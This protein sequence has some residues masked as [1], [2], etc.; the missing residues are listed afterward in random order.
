MVLSGNTRRRIR[1]DVMVLL[2]LTVAVSTL[3]SASSNCIDVSI[4]PGSTELVP[5]E[6]NQF[7][8]IEV[9]DWEYSFKE[10]SKP[11]MVF[12]TTD[13][14]KP[15]SETIYTEKYQ[16]NILEKGF[17]TFVRI[18]VPSVFYKDGNKYTT[19]S[20]KFRISCEKGVKQQPVFS[21][22][23]NPFEYLIIT[24]ETFYDVV[25]NEFKEWKKINDDKIYQV[26]IKN[27][28]EIIQKQFTWV[29]GSCG[30]AT[31]ATNGNPWI[32]DGQ[33]I[34]DH[35][36][37]FNDTQAKIR[38]YI[39]YCWDVNDTRYVLLFGNKDVVPVRMVTSYATGDGGGSWYNDYS[40]ASDMY[41]SCLHKC[42]NN[43]TNSYW[44]ENR[45]YQYGWDDV[46]WG[47]DLCVGRVT[48]DLITEAR[49]W[50]N[51]TKAYC[52]GI[53]QGEYLK[54]HIVANKNNANQISAQTWNM[55]GDEF[56]DNQTFL[57]NRNISSTQWNNLDHYVNGEMSNWTD[58]YQLIHHAGHGGTL[59]A[60][61][62]PANCNNLLIP[63]FVY[64]E[65][66][67]T[68]DFGTDTSSRMERWISDDGCAFAGI[69]NSAY[70]WF[71]A[72][73]Y[74]GEEMFNQMFNV[75]NTLIFCEAHND[76][77]E[78][79]GHP[80]DSVFGMIVKE[81][82]FFGD[83][84]MEYQWYPEA[85]NPPQFINVSGGNNGTTFL[86]KIILNW[87]VCVDAP[88]YWLQIATDS[89]FSNIVVNLT[90]VSKYCYPSNFTIIGEIV[91]FEL[92]MTLPKQIYYTRIKA[93]RRSQ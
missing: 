51:K 5:L 56:Q 86:G 4:E 39:R 3:N 50:I 6:D 18:S 8:G 20:I 29:N 88:F 46:D 91:S 80:N 84:A 61:Y 17:D 62:Q 26:V 13:Q 10:E 44:M 93:F 64:T 36:S 52:N 65:G 90:N 49:N 74:Y 24:T 48:V 83:P 9:V 45:C 72:S 38:N 47:Y 28:S 23:K 59:W 92:P 32:A 35:Y 2:I 27:V 89:N 68:G 19:N 77:R 78:I 81:T 76:A 15:S 57:N 43:N 11:E 30:D 42:M 73:T 67:N 87:S 25:N 69:S 7:K 34:H 60:P 79:Y 55:I 58:G 66:C 40:H 53:Y 41:Y 37:L 21:S 33:E 71:T 16:Y 70:G 12:Y 14:N 75:S 85:G 22:C 54:N 63:Q 31:N 82:N 1:A